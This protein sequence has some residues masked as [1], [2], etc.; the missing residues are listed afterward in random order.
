MGG[1][2]I[3]SR[4]GQGVLI[5]ITNRGDESKM[6][7]EVEQVIRS[8]DFHAEQ[9]GHLEDVDGFILAPHGHQD[10]GAVGGFDQRPDEIVGAVGFAW[11][12]I[13]SW[14]LDIRPLPAP[15]LG[16]GEWFLGEEQGIAAVD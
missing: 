2:N 14:I 9:V 3:D 10:E 11:H 5:A 16:S 15:F 7:Q 6:E 4:G 12:V 8:Q 13:R 1:K